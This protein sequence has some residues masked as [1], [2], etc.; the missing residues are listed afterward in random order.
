[1]Q[2]DPQMQSKDWIRDKIQALRR[3]SGISFNQDLFISILL[4]LIS[5]SGRH[6][7]L[8]ASEDQLPNVISMTNKVFTSIFGFT[9]ANINCNPNQT[10]SD[11]VQHLFVPVRDGNNL[12]PTSSHQYAGSKMAS[13]RSVSS[14]YTNDSS[15]NG[16]VASHSSRQYPSIPSSLRGHPRDDGKSMSSYDRRSSAA[17]QNTMSSKDASGRLGLKPTHPTGPISPIDFTFRRKSQDNQIGMH[18]YRNYDDKDYGKFKRS[19]FGDSSS[20]RSSFMPTRIAQA[21][22]VKN[23]HQASDHVQATLLEAIIVQQLK[24]Q[25]AT[26]NVPHPFIVVAILPQDAPPRSILS[27]LID[28]FYVSYRFD[29]E[30]LSD[31]PNAADQR[32]GPMQP[33]KRI[34]L[35]KSHEIKDLANA[36][37]MININVDIVVYIRDIVVGIRT[38]RL[39]HSGLTSRAS[40]DLV[41]VVKALSALFR[42]EYVTPDLVSIAAEKV[43]SHRLLLKP[44]AVYDR[45]ITESVH[46]DAQS[47]LNSLISEPAEVLPA[48]IVMEI[49][50]VVHV[51]V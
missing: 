12:D 26:Y 8:T 20:S 46:S 25:S 19:D 4:C 38:H 36:V 43:F 27:Q 41:L 32:F 30:S 3:Q 44:E 33:P 16:S 13:N 17:G 21:V 6:L 50:R 24:I 40:Q 5:G 11:F 34:A 35:V 10:A 49:L 28:R 18:S 14:Q 37:N 39:V 29:D 23:L 1:M 31:T 45:V 42:R 7:I 22:I 15:W 9:C 48:D 51:P 47:D 2:P